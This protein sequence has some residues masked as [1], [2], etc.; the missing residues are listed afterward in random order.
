MVCVVCLS[1]SIFY[2]ALIVH[3]HF[4]C[5]S[6]DQMW[7]VIWKEKMFDLDAKYHKMSE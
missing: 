1:V 7:L 6:G 2:S 5:P 3:E 4:C